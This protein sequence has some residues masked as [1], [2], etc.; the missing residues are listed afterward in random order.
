MCKTK[1]ENMGTCKNTV[2]LII[3][4]YYAI[5]AILARLV[6]QCWYGRKGKT[7]SPIKDPILL[8]SATTIARKIRTKQVSM[9]IFD[10]ISLVSKSILSYKSFVFF[11]GNCFSFF[12]HCFK[13]LMI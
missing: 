1:R 10:F 5:V 13:F 4:V 2:I 12:K 6:F 9:L 11:G 3:N 7:M 8:D